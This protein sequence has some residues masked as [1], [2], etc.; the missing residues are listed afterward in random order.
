M[1]KKSRRIVKIA[2]SI[3]LFVV[4]LITIYLITDRQYQKQMDPIRINDVHYIAS[5]IED[6]HS[7]TGY[8]PFQLES[9]KISERIVVNLDGKLF[10]NPDYGPFNDNIYSHYDFVSELSKVLGSDTC[11][12]TDKQKHPTYAPNF[13]SYVVHDGHY[14]LAAH[15]F[16]PNLK[17]RFVQIKHNR[18][19]KYEIGSIS[20]PEKNIQQFSETEH[21]FRNPCQQR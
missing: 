16:W 6:Y 5:L 7:K 11:V 18:Y 20:I 17:A 21:T 1:N 3:T 8:F 2:L 12:P 9:D 10:V 15:L 13:Y 19:Y 14:F 4:C